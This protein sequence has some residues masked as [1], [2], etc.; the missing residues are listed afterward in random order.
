MEGPPSGY[1]DQMAFGSEPNAMYPVQWSAML[2]NR[3]P[4]SWIVKGVI[5]RN[6]MTVMYGDA[7]STKT[8]LALDMAACVGTGLNYHGFS[9]EEGVV[10]YIGGEGNNAFS[11]RVAAWQKGHGTSVEEYPCYYIGGRVGLIDEMSMELLSGIMRQYQEHE[12]LPVQLVV[13]DTWQRHLGADENSTRDVARACG[14]IN[15]YLRDALD[16]AVL[17]LHHTGWGTQARMRGSSVLLA[18]CDALFRV[19]FDDTNNRSTLH[20]ERMRDGAKPPTLVFRGEKLD[21]SAEGAEPEES[22]CVHR[23]QEDPKKGELDLEGKERRVL[24]LIRQIHADELARLGDP[25]ISEVTPEALKALVV[26]ERL[27]D[28]DSKGRQALAGAVRR[29]IDKSLVVRRGQ[30]NMI[31]L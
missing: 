16:C 6:T 17:V 14:N 23:S 2:Q 21:V 24:Q 15:R 1:E 13:I 3:R 27:Y 5:E 22:W 7:G 8:F 18:E 28:V 29:L 26:S 11:R 30:R 9:V 31:P 4:V 12:G 20:C 19:L 25:N 10:F